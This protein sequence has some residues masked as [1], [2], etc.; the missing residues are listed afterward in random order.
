VKGI[1]TLLSAM[2]ILLNKFP[3]T[4]LE[5]AGD[6][7]ERERL[8]DR[9]NAL[10]VESNVRFVGWKSHSSTA[11]RRWDIYAQPSAAEGFGIAALGARL[12]D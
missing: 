6:G 3:A 1:S 5:I 11:L 8:E 9:A 12:E 7:P 2:A 4:M 10:A